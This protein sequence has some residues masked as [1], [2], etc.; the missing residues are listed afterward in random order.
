MDQFDRFRDLPESVRFAIWRQAAS[1]PRVVSVFET[2]TAE[3]RPNVEAYP[4]YETAMISRT[5]PPAMLSVCQESRTTALQIYKAMDE[6]IRT[7]GAEFDIP[8]YVNPKVDIVLRGKR[9][10]REGDAFRH[11]LGVWINESKPYAATRTLA[12]DLLAVT[13]RRDDPFTSQ[14][15]KDYYD[16]DDSTTFSDEIVHLLAVTTIQQIAACAASGMKDLIIV[17]GNDDD[18][19]EATL[20][21]LN[22]NKNQWTP[23]EKGALGVAAQLRKDLLDHW[24]DLG[25]GPLFT[26][27]LPDISVMTVQRV[28]NVSFPQFQK[29]PSELQDMVWVYALQHPRIITAINC[30]DDKH[31]LGTTRQPSLLSVCRA[32]RQLLIEQGSHGLPGQC[33]IYYNSAVD[34]VLLNLNPGC[35]FRP[36]SK[37][38]IESIGIPAFVST[39]LSGYE[40]RS[41]R[42]LREIVILLGNPQGDCQMQVVDVEQHVIS[43]CETSSREWRSFTAQSPFTY[44]EYLRKSI[45]RHFKI[46]ETY[47]RLCKKKGKSTDDWVMPTVRV[48][49]M[50]PVSE[51]A[52]PYMY[53]HRYHQS[54]DCRGTCSHRG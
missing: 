48:A 27:S 53:Q 14:L 41:F 44:A 46:L 10:C 31:Y 26:A 4:T 2:H 12:V 7:K 20:V 11:R 22:S 24:G 42:G 13:R 32:S 36:Y 28:P 21:P 33:D 5:R 35:D 1:V 23:R 3:R 34:T 52:S 40:V 38:K 16:R 18:A 8:I 43:A 29:L 49:R 54:H 25:N 19:S 45:Q 50:V 9:A 47:Q 30:K 37:H 51:T 39:S 17:V 15:R 6:G